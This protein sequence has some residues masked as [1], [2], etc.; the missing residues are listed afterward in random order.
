ML[1]DNKEV[2]KIMLLC[3]IITEHYSRWKVYLPHTVSQK[4]SEPRMKSLSNSLLLV[5]CVTRNSPDQLHSPGNGKIRLPSILGEVWSVPLLQCSDSKI[6]PLLTPSVQLTE[7]FLTHTS[8]AG[9][10]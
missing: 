6:G 3:Y 9:Y 8:S 2:L 10:F 5:S 7:D 4:Q 1:V